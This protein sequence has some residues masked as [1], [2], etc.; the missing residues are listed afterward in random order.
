M[1]LRNHPYIIKNDRSL[2]VAIEK[3]IG[4][5]FPAPL[6]RGS[7]LYHYRGTSVIAGNE[8]DRFGKFIDIHMIGYHYLAEKCLVGKKRQDPLIYLKE[9][10][11]TAK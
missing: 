3:H 8:L 7:R 5:H 4:I 10:S 9:L 6:D 1:T 2:P 11:A